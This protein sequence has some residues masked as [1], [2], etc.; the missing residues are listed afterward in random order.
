[1]GLF[2]LVLALTGIVLAL[3]PVK[4]ATS[5]QQTNE[6]QKVQVSKLLSKL[7]SQY[8]ECIELKVDDKGF[9]S[10]LAIDEEGELVDGVIDIHSGKVVA[11]KAAQS[12]FIEFC[13]KFHRSLLMGSAGRFIVGLT[14]FLL[15]LI[16]LSGLGLL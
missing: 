12:E 4:N 2:V 11:K 5:G 3:E 1:A 13:R 8:L 16:A 14:S 9:V 15:L 10:L 7:T 6:L